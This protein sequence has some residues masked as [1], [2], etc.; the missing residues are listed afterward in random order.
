MRHRL[1]P[2]SALRVFETV[3]RSTSLRRAAAELQVTHSAIS[4]HIRDLEAWF[5][6][7]LIRATPRGTMLTPE[8]LRLHAHVSAGFALFERGV[9]ELRHTASGGK[10]VIWCAPGFAAHWII[11]RYPSLEQALPGI[12]IILRPVDSSPDLVRR[13]ADIEIR[14][15]ERPEAGLINETLIRPI[16]LAVASPAWL[17][18]NPAARDPQSLARL[19]LIHEKNHDEWR[20][21]FE[22]AGVTEIQ[23]LTGPRFWIATAA[24]EAARLGHGVALLPEPVAAEDLASGNLL[25]V[26]DA[27]IQLEAY[28]LV[29]AKER[30]HEPTIQRFRRWIKAALGTGEA[31]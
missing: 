25:R 23:P 13:E 11:P 17:Q 2:L 16:M 24:L 21:W 7:K 5:G 20:Q 14:Y 1:P 19:P 4:Q 26:V 31:P 22:A 15:G 3:G 27:P 12:E 18:A 9:E 30:L 6:V 8:G 28:T 29:V 10:L